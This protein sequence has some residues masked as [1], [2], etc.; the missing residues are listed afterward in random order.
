MKTI[1]KRTSVKTKVK[2]YS[3]EE[4]CSIRGVFVCIGLTDAGFISFG[5]DLNDHHTVLYLTGNIV[6]P[7]IKIFWHNNSFIKVDEQINI[8]IKG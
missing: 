3:W 5:Y 6:Q 1:V 2:E 8:S 4:M 7:A